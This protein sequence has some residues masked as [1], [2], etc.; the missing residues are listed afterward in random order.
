[1]SSRRIQ[2]LSE[3]EMQKVALAR[4]LVTKPKIMLMDEPLS[5]LDSPTKTA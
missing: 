5:Q 1:M 2:G 4:V 3:G